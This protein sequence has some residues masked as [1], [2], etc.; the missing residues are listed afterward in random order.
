MQFLNKVFGSK[1]QREL[2]KLQPRVQAV[3]AL[4]PEMK[5]LSDAAL[6]AKTGELK[7]KLANG[8]SLDDILVEA[9]AV[10]R[11]AGWRVLKMRHYDVQLIGGMVLHSG[12]IAEMRTGEGKTLVA[13]L[14]AYLNALEERGVHIVTVND[15]LANRDAEWMGKIYRFMGMSV[16]TIVHGYDDNHKQKQYGCD[17]T[18]GTN[19]EYGFDYLRDNMKFS[20][21]DYVQGR[22]LR[23]AIIDEVDSILIDEARTPLIISGPAEESADKYVGVNKVVS[24]LQPERDFTVDEKSKSAVLTDEGTDRVERLLDVG[25]LFSPENT[26]WFHHVAKALA[27]HGCYK[28]DVDYLVHNG[29]VLIIDE[30]T[31]RTMEGRRWSDGLHQAI[32][33][34]EGVKIQ[35]ENVTLATITYQNFYRM[36]DKLSGMTGTADTEAE[37]FSKIYEL[38]VMV[39]PTNKP[40]VRDDR[41]DLVYKTEAEKFRAVVDDIKERHERGQPVLVGTKN[42]DKSEVISRLLKK[43][44]IEHVVLNAKFHRQEGEIIAQA[45]QLGAVT[46]STNMAGRGTD[47]LLGGNAEYLARA[48]VA[49][50]QMGEA[51]GDPKKEQRILAEFRWLSGSP[52]SIPRELVTQDKTSEF[53]NQLMATKRGE[54]GFEELDVGQIREE[55][56]QKAREWIDGIIERYAEHLE[57]HEKVCKAAKQQVLGAGGLHVLGT[58]RH[59][60]RRV[61]NQLRGRAGRQ[62]DP[63]CSQF[64][65][66]LEDDLMRIFGGDKLLGMMERL[67]MEDDMPIE[68]KMVTKSIENAQKRVEGHNFDIRKNLIEYDDVMNLQRKSIYGLRRTVLGEDP[69]E[70]EMLDLIERV[71]SYDVG[72]A[73]PPKASPEEWDLDSLKARVK[74][75]FGAELSFPAERPRYQELEL[76]VYEAVEKRWR[77]KQKELGDDFVVVGADLMPKDAMPVT[78][79]VKE[80]VWRFLL[81]QFYLGQIDRHWRDHLTQMDHLREGIGLRG[82]GSKDPKIEYKREGHLLFASMMREVDHNV[83]AEIFNVKLMSPEEVRRE[84]E[85]QRRAME[86]M[87]RAA[88]L[89]GAENQDEADAVAPSAP[90]A[91]QKEAAQA[92]GKK[93]LGRNDPCW[94]GSGKKYKACHLRED[95]RA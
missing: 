4:E 11:E 17:I 15:Y 10:V 56:K 34:K 20:L 36:Y 53:F 3:T 51:R 54:E 22:G 60:S 18:Y 31:G 9:F 40:M 26:E 90:A 42:V 77:K 39:I 70:E 21:S 91:K 46:I 32:E 88:E 49:H 47:I 29:E 33:A 65:L 93:K 83:A 48:D 75:L 80:P 27:A 66:S 43:H 19:S 1:N 87:Q 89:K 79:K 72:N 62:G 13:T 23:Y 61:D 35:R 50:E 30:H 6:Q 57:K 5:K 71:V 78:A 7:Q 24:Q 8:A 82:Y 28:R 44:S 86:A 41:Q 92:Q 55:A 68:A 81:R 85:R 58:E 94:C 2:R 25:N 38:D 63:G 74:G 69:M 95:A 37:E 84:A 76:M 67:G 12:K 16:G 73:C 45:G 59:E 14:P 52:D 64:Y